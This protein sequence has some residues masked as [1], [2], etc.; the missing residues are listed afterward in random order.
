MNKLGGRIEFLKNIDFTDNK[1]RIAIVVI[2]VVVLL[3]FLK[4]QQSKKNGDTTDGFLSKFKKKSKSSKKGSRRSK[5]GSK[6]TSRKSK[7]V[8]DDDL[9]DNFD[10][11]ESDSD[12]N[13]GGGAITSALRNDAEDLY[14]L[15]HEG[16]AK[17]MQQDQFESI[18]GDLAD[19]Y[20]FIE[21]KQLYNS[22]I[23]RNM[24]PLKSITV[25]DYI[26]I[27]RKEDDDDDDF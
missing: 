5:K 16:L 10:D 18:A 23:D 17:G 14:N 15:V 7:R 22:H 19:E 9:G 2:L 4:W 20:S 26:N 8:V 6:R 13:T 3:I 21:L 27:L 11:S 25:T 1:V 24:D 12:D